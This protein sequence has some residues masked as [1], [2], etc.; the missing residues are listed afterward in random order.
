M[1]RCLVSTHWPDLAIARNAITIG[2]TC[3]N[4]DQGF[5]SFPTRQTSPWEPSRLQNLQLVLTPRRLMVDRAPDI[6]AE[7][8]TTR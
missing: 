4:R 6:V 5:A 1:G 8:A 7:A 2:N 3:L